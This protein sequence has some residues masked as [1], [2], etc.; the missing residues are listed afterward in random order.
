MLILKREHRY[1]DNLRNYKVYIDSDYKGNISDDSM[2]EYQ[3]TQGE[4]TI[5]LKI[6]WFKS[7]KLTF[8]YEGNDIIYLICHSGMEG[9][10]VFLW[11]LYITIWSRNYISLKQIS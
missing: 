5:Y 8:T 6:D 4:H 2:F 10:K 1:A 9:Y 11:P 7:R 3:L